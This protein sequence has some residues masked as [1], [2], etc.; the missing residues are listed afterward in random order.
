MNIWALI[1]V[2]LV[3]FTAVA[4]FFVPLGPQA[5]PPI[6]WPALAAIFVSCSLGLLFVFG[7]QAINPQSA[8]VWRR[9]SW[10]LNPFNFQEPLQFFH[11]GAYV[12]LADGIVTF[13]RVAYSSTPFYAEALVPLVIGLGILVGLQITMVVFRSKMTRDGA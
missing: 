9:P 11:L 2:A 8:K 12:G 1:R 6:S 10:A 3:L 7:I 4:T 5:K 13:A